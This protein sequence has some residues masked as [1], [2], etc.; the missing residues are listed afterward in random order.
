MSSSRLSQR[1]NGG[2]GDGPAVGGTHT[3]IQI[4]DVDVHF[5][6]AG[7]EAILERLPEPWR[8]RK[9]IR[10]ALTKAPVYNPYTGAMRLDAK[11]VLGPTGSDPE[12]AGR[13]LFVDAGVDLAINIPVGEYFCPLVEPDLNAAYASAVNEWQ[14]DTWLGGFKGHGR[15]R[16]SISVAVNNIPSAV[17]E[18]DKW[19]G[20]PRFVQ[21]LVPHH[22]GAPYGSP[23]FDPLW[24]AASRHQLPIALH[25]NVGLESYCTPVGFIQRYPEYN[26]IGHPLFIAQ[27][28]V[29][30]ITSGAFDRFP[31][32]RFVFVEGGF[33]LYGPLVSRLDRSIERLQGQASRRPSDYVR[34]R[35]R[36]SSQPVEEPEAFEDLARMWSWCGA[37]DVLMFSTDYPHWDF[38]SP[39]QALPVRLA[40]PRER[41]IMAENARA[42]YGLRA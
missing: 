9:N 11:P 3:P 38:D 15:Y 21:V 28:L 17:A 1:S 4:I 25:S 27:H 30:L 7:A 13:Q 40:P 6:P 41:A 14:S 8:S 35:I 37:E 31:S 34:E 2:P 26:G 5:K 23:Q 24:A 39:D 10:R 42:L 20:D 19:A 16:G 18:V 29:S 36:F 33:S 22:A 32:L 12:L